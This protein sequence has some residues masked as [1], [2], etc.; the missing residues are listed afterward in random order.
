MVDVGKLRI[1]GAWDMIYLHDMLV[2]K[3]LLIVS[4]RG[5]IA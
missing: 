2:E 1:A 3:T 5:F 4:P